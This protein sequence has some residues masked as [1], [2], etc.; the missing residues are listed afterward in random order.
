MWVNSNWWCCSLTTWRR[1]ASK[2]LRYQ[3]L[4][5]C[6]PEVLLT[7]LKG[8]VETLI[9][10]QLEWK[11][12][13][14]QKREGKRYTWQTRIAKMKNT[15]S[16]FSQPWMNTKTPPTSI[17]LE[18][19][20]TSSKNHNT[21]LSTNNRCLAQPIAKMFLWITKTQT[22]ENL[23]FYYSIIMLF[24]VSSPITEAPA[25]SIQFTTKR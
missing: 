7:P 1:N 3:L 23:S 19:N 20:L 18:H 22:L 9:N 15:F 16:S 13:I 17:N 11:I 6:I 12:F 10:I 24:L 5:H 25:Y 8:W 14:N 4:L 21:P 2:I